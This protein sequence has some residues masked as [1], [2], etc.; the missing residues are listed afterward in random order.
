M[1]EITLSMLNAPIPKFV[2]P[3]LVRHIT[4]PQN[5]VLYEIVRSVE[6]A[7]EYEKSHWLSRNAME[8]FEVVPRMLGGNEKMS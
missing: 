3:L 6:G 7:A 2:R 8:N 1:S 5:P 4:V